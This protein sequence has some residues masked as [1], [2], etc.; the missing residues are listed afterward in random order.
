MRFD[1]RLLK[2][3]E[4]EDNPRTTVYGTIASG[5]VIAAADPTTTNY[6]SIVLATSVAV[7]SYWVAHGYAHWVGERLER[8]DSPGSARRS[9]HRLAQ[10]LAHEW[11]LAEGASIPLLA[12]VVTW[13]TGATLAVAETVALAS[14]TAALA[15]FEVAAGLRRHVRPPQLLANAAVGLL[16]GSALFAVK[17]VLH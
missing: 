3:I 5:L 15:A 11:P 16:L 2:W 10:A 7:A 4:P 17:N 14:A 9:R 1:D 12:L 13:A 6:S 8:N